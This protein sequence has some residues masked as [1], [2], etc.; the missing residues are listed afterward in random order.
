MAPA[1]TSSALITQHNFEDLA[2]SKTLHGQS[3]NE[4]HH[5]DSFISKLKNKDR[6]FTPTVVDNYLDN[7][8]ETKPEN[9]TE[10]AKVER[11]NA[12]KA[13]A[14]SFYDLAT[15]F[16]EAQFGNTYSLLCTHNSF[17]AAQFTY[18]W[19]LFIMNDFI[20]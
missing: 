20:N 15:D 14:N 4:D 6:E 18:L 5:Q 2:L 12:Y 16:Y 1:R 10:E 13:V 11:Q 17:S 7:W 19:A 8:K 9:E 3:W